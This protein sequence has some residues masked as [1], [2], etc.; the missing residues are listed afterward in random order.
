M[1]LEADIYLKSSKSLE[2]V[3]AILSKELFGGLPF[4][5]REN[6]IRDEIPA[7]YIE[8][9]IMGMEIIL[10]GGDIDGITILQIRPSD[11]ITNEEIIDSSNGN[12]SEYLKFMLRSIE[13]IKIM[14]SSDIE[15]FE[16]KLET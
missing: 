9:E 12:L 10:V 3:G 8:P 11:N 6:Y 2:E 1:F 5:G 7:I 4:G 16:A 15:D 14:S 13:G